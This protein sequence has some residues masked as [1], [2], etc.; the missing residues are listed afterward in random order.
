MAF[1][2]KTRELC[3]GR[4][5]PAGARRMAETA[6]LLPDELFPNVSLRQ[7]V[8]NFPFPLSYLFAAHPQA[9]GKVLGI[10]YRKGSPGFQR[11]LTSGSTDRQRTLPSHHRSR[12]C[13]PTTIDGEW[14]G[15]MVP[16]NLRPGEAATILIHWGF[17]CPLEPALCP[18][19][20]LLSPIKKSSRNNAGP[21]RLLYADRFQPRQVVEKQ[22]TKAPRQRC[23][24]S[25]ITR[26]SSGRKR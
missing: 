2:C 23:S 17:R 4:P 9:M 20:W 1:S 26:R 18:Q 8:V 19:N 25:P 7:W 14:W 10:V 15:R 16:I 24:V 13:C 21:S 12:A 6:A 22:P 5:A 11:D 3:R